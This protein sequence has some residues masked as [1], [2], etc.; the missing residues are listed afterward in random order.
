MLHELST[1]RRNVLRL[2]ANGFGAVAL[3]SLL[4]GPLGATERLNPL[5][6]KPPHFETKAKS[7]IFLFMVGAPGQMDTF[8]PKPSLAKYA[9]QPLRRVMADPRILPVATPLVLPSPWEFGRYGQSGLPVSALYPHLAKCVDDICFVRNF[10][11]ESVV[12]APA[13]YQV[14]SGRILMGYP[15]LGSWVTYGLRKRFGEST[16]LCRDVPAG[17]HT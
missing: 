5:S 10:Y 13:M 9:G 8:D 16:R 1:S 7:I 11:T 15:S 3:E 17:R 12:H 14:Q 4:Q 6:A 2:A